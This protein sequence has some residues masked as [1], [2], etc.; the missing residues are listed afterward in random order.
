MNLKICIV[1]FINVLWALMP[2]NI[3]GCGPQA[4]PK[5]YFT[6]F[7]SNKTA[8]VQGVEPFMYTALLQ[9]YDDWD[10]YFSED[11]ATKK[12]EDPVLTEWI[13][14]SGAQVSSAAASELV[15][16]IEGKVLENLMGKA[17]GQN[18]L[19]GEEFAKFANNTL[20][21]ALQKTGKQEALSY[22]LFAKKVQDQTMSN[23]MWEPA[24]NR[25]VK[26]INAL[27]MQAEKAY[28]ASKDNFLKYKYGFM[29]CRLAFYSGKP[30]LCIEKVNTFF[31]DKEETGTLNA[32]ALSYKAGAYYE[33]QIYPD[34]A[35]WY[36]KAFE[37]ANYDRKKIYLSFLWSIRK[38]DESLK[39]LVLQKA[40]TNKDKALVEA[41][42]GLHGLE[43]ALPNL[44]EV[45]RLDKTNPLLR[46]LALREINKLE[47]NFLTPRLNR[48]AGSK[49]SFYGYNNSKGGTDLTQLNKLL[50][51]CEKVAKD[52]DVPQTGFFQ[53]AAAYLS[54]MAGDSERALQWAG[55]MK[56]GTSDENL[57]NQ[58]RLIG[59]M[60]GIAKSKTIT[61]TDEKA[62]LPGLE[63]LFKMAEKDA[64]YRIFMRNLFTQVLAPK[65]YAQGDVYKTALCLG[66]AD[67]SKFKNTL[68]VDEEFFIGSGT[69]GID[70]VRSEMNT[71]EVLKLYSFLQQPGLKD[72]DAFITRQTSFGLAEV[73]DFLGTSYLR[74]H[75]WES[76]VSWLQKSDEAEQLTALVVNQNTYDYDTLTVDPFHD[77]LNDWQRY[78][79][80]LKVPMGKLDFAK[81]MRGFE[82][83]LETTTDPA[84]KGRIAYTLGAAYYNIS[85]YGN[86]WMALDYGR[87]TVLWN[88]GMYTGWRKEYFEVQKARS[89]FEKAVALSTQNKE[90]QAA[91]FFLAAKCA[92]RQI[93]RPDYN[94]EQGQASD[95]AEK[96]FQRAFRKHPLLGQFKSQYGQTK[97]Y[98]YAFNRCSYLRDFK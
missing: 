49:E 21:R 70:Y 51:F 36:A 86:A 2:Q 69:M 54:Y 76:A 89:Y 84:E 12:G 55:K 78:D 22:L 7:F 77:Y 46:V 18:V 68:P 3:I 62:W 75:D 56:Q 6:R 24:A 17:S 61:H 81:K 41:L 53:T 33:M 26:N 59:L 50:A 79:K 30:A 96:A 23:D 71:Q 74:D 19:P 34:A 91:A 11:K 64:E 9:F 47:E 60:A 14:Y 63:W 13:K 52:T 67:L 40:P 31:G 88:N 39:M 85:Y 1:V 5:D 90:F 98:K 58:S 10:G 27:L 28:A 8:G 72:F 38:G 80:T 65:Y 20:Y 37:Q 66:V 43:V 29:Q 73:V 93:I 95:R 87:S 16:E 45:Y 92:Q 42:Y 15:Y 44:Q 25:D 97:F 83:Q 4:D 35:Y 82:K 94:Y 48:Q 32:M 57:V